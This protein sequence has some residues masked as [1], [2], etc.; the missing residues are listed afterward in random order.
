M[1]SVVP[2]EGPEVV[3][4]PPGGPEVVRRPSQMLGN[5]REALPE[6]KIWSGD[7]F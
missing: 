6:D 2:P 1:W 7:P 5:G 3:G 4:G